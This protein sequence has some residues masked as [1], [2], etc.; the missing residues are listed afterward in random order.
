MCPRGCPSLTILLSDW[1]EEMRKIDA[2][3][4]ELPLCLFLLNDVPFFISLTPLLLYFYIKHVPFLFLEEDIKWI[5]RELGL[6]N[7]ISEVAAKVM[8]LRDQT[9]TRQ[10][11]ILDPEIY[12]G[13]VHIQGLEQF[14]EAWLTKLISVVRK[15]KDLFETFEK[16]RRDS[17]IISFA[18]L[19]MT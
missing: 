14:A 17:H 9:R 10:Q 15:A 7:V 8:H 12:F 5:R 11:Q 6:L 3:K 2:F 4:C 19:R 13:R 16:Q 1:R 18:A